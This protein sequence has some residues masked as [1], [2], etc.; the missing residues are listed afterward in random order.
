MISRLLALFVLVW[1]GDKGTGHLS[2]K[3]DHVVAR[4]PHSPPPLP[5]LTVPGAVDAKEYF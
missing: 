1:T 2:M 3:R 4:P 5:V